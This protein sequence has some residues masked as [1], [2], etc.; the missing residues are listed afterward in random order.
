M[1]VALA[2]AAGSRVVILD[3]PTAGVD[4]YSRKS[5][6]DLL[7]KYKKGQLCGLV[8]ESIISSASYIIIIIELYFN[9]IKSGMSVPFTGVYIHTC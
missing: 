4:P 5:I 3:E 1:S 9:T 6:W 2:F 7:L 8:F